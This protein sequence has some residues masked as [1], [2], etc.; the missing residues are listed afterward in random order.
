MLRAR[1]SR[2]RRLEAAGQLPLDFEPG[3][4]RRL[5]AARQLWLELRP[6][7][8][9]EREYREWLLVTPSRAALPPNRLG[10]VFPIRWSATTPSSLLAAMRRKRLGHLELV[11]RM[12]PGRFVTVS[13]GGN[14]L[15]PPL[16]W[17]RIG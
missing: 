3:W 6:P 17:P 9:L 15:R 10:V 1:R 11:A 14:P 16:L 4:D 8:T 2:A 13:V 5:A 7:L 12:T